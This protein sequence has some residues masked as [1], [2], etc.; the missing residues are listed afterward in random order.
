MTD[1]LDH[2]VTDPDRGADALTAALARAEVELGAPIAV[3]RVALDTFDGR[4]HGAGLRLEHRR[5]LANELVLVDRTGA[6]PAHLPLD[7]PPTAPDELPAGPFRA[8]LAA[9]VQE[10]ALLPLVSVASTVRS[11]QRRDRRGKATVSV[12]LYEQLDVVGDR[13]ASL[14]LPPW[15][16]EVRGTVGH[17]AALQQV[18]DRLGG[19]GFSARPGDLVDVVA[20]SLG[21]D[22]RCRTSSPTVPL[23][24][25]EPALAAFQRVLLNL[26]DA[27]EANL[28]GTID[29]IDPEF[30]HELRV[31]VRRS[32]S[33]LSKAKGVVP[34]DVRQ[35]HRVELAWLGD[36]TSPARDLDVYL[37][38]WDGYVAPLEPAAATAL[39]PVRTELER[40]RVAAH[41]ALSAALRSDRYE[42]LVAKWER[43]LRE[44]AAT[45]SGAPVAG[46][47]VAE[48]VAS[49]Q[50]RVLSRGRDINSASP[51]ESLHDLR[52]DAKQLRYLLECFGSLM[53]DKPRKAFVSSLK[54]LQD[55]LGA[56][57]D[58]EVHVALLRELA[59]TLHGRTAVDAATLLAMGQLMEVL[60]RRRIAEREDFAARFAGYDTTATARSLSALLRG[61]RSR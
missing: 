8:R 5:G 7:R 1:P 15:A 4:L 9:V 39:E 31:A 56:H 53:P 32:R 20:E 52:K 54:S 17:G 19:R 45:S 28:L 44:P 14:L 42:E 57:Q 59:E 13:A 55:N 50:R 43:W 36:L 10:R 35:H 29:D 24:P 18:L 61:I 6:P 12:D 58:A 49:A 41:E 33:V 37:L 25:D 48:R 51:P 27:I 3:S 16:A 34:E 60:D 30:L 22:V 40:R 11:G 38:E 46:A 23:D 26:A 47:V 21:I 2:L